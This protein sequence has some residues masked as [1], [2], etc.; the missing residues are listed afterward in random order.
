MQREQLRQLGGEAAGEPVA[1]EQQRSQLAQL[2]R[3]RRQRPGELVRM[4]VQHLQLPECPDVFRDAA[5]ARNGV[6]TGGGGCT[7]P[8]GRAGGRVS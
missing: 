6:R 8:G 4:Q 1:V 3:G 2:A 7:K 5:C